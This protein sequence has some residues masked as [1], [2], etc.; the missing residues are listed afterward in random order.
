MMLLLGIPLLVG[1]CGG[2]A[3]Q[4]APGSEADAIRIE[5]I[6]RPGEEKVT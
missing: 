6:R 3:K 2:F 5:E 4:D 1:G